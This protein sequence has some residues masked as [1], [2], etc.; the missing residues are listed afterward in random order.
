MRSMHAGHLRDGDED[1][2]LAGELATLAVP[3]LGDVGAALLLER[4]GELLTQRHRV[5]DLGLL[6]KA[7]GPPARH[8]GTAALLLAHGHAGAARE[9]G[10]GARIPGGGVLGGGGGLVREVGGEAREERAVVVLLAHDARRHRRH[11]RGRGGR[12]GGAGVELGITG[13]VG[14][15][16]GRAL[17][18]HEGG[19]H[20]SERLGLIVGVEDAGDVV[21]DMVGGSGID[22]V[23]GVEGERAAAR[24]C[25]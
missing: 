4:L 19:K 3:A 21:R 22:A 9:L 13:H 12:G 6:A 5:L 8:L 11:G 17:L 24:Q 25:I 1:R 14:H 7:L 20:R 18:D 2:A 23:S 10:G 16:D 15:G